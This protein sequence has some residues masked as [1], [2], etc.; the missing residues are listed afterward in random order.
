MEYTQ[1][2]ID[3]LHVGGW[4]YYN[5]QFVLGL[6][7]QWLLTH[8]YYPYVVVEGEGEDGIDNNTWIHYIEPVIEENY[9]SEN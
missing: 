7:D 2:G 1:N 9:E 4:T 5:N 8:G 3:F 6:T